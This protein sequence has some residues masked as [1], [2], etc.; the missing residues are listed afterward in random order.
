FC[1]SGCPPRFE[2]D[3]AQYLSKIDEKIIEQQTSYYPLTTDVVT[4]AA[5]G[6]DAVDFVYFNRLVRFANPDSVAKFE[7][8]AATHLAKLD[9]A[10]IAKQKDSYPL[11][12][13]PIGGHKLGESGEPVN[14]VIANRLVRLCCEDCKKDLYKDPVAVF[15]KIDVAAKKK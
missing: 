12:A 10:V 4:D 6:K 7:K 14:V 15:S 8:D 5:L 11:D 1:C 3:P 9:D 13:C 2:K